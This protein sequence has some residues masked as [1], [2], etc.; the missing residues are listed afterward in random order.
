MTTCKEPLDWEKAWAHLFFSRRFFFEP[1]IQ[2]FIFKC[3]RVAHGALLNFGNCCGVFHNLDHSYR[4]MHRVWWR[5]GASAWPRG[6][7]A[8]SLL[9]EGQVFFF[10][11][12]ELFSRSM[13]LVFLWGIERKEGGHGSCVGYAFN[14]PEWQEEKAGFE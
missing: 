5:L 13:L 9:S 1:V 7:K 3:S 12:R 4:R 8:R 14:I 11:T 6:R 2:D 10:L